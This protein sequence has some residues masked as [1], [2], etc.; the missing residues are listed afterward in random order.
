MKFLVD[1]PVSPGIARW[2]S[3]KGH[4][5]IHAS[6]VG[7]HDAADRVILQVARKNERV[8]ITA[9]LNFPQLLAVSK[10]EAPGI[11]LFR[12][13]NY[14]EQEMRNLL[15]RVFEN[16]KEEHLSGS[17]TVVVKTRIRRTSLPID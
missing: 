15:I 10:S 11:I 16:V 9:D 6:G 4:D 7:L 17:V 3:G 12:G 5:A 2:L 14:N 8:I 13:G 1:M